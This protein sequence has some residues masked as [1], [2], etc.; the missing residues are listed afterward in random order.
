MKNKHI[1]Q[2]NKNP[3]LQSR[4]YEETDLKVQTFFSNFG[5]IQA[6]FA[7]LFTN[8]KCKHIA[9]KYVCNSC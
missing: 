7:L 9:L 5:Q 4:Y 8:K 3:L 1:K 2:T 6:C